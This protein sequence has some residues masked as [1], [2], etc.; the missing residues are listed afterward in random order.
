MSQGEVEA[1]YKGWE[2]IGS[3][4]SDSAYRDLFLH[5]RALITDSC[6]FLTEYGAT[7]KPIIHL[8]RRD[9][10]ITPLPPS[11]KVFDTFYDVYNLDEMQKALKLVIEEG[12]DPKC[13]ERR[14]AFSDANISDGCAS[15]RI[16][17]YLKR[18]MRR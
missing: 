3:A 16:I 8:K 5:S 2:T 12:L 11:K 9:T 14:K 1:Y 7:G 13:V 4:K 18:L 10:G 15:E 6:S 17:N